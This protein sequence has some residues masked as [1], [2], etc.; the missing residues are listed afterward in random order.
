MTARFHKVF[1]VVAS[2]LV[3]IA[4]VWGFVLA[5]S[6]FK[7]RLQRLD[8]QRLTDLQDI[9]RE[10]QA[11]VRDED[12]KETL[13]QPLPQTLEEAAGRARYRK[14]NLYDPETGE[15]YRYTRKDETTYEL[16][17][18]FALPRD[19]DREVFWNHAA[20]EQCF[21]IDALDPP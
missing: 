13:K 3:A 1:F 14:L 4:I 6:P 16:C 2:T 20:G 5:G 15:P 7:T 12:E 19:A 8:D 10:I 18:T 11:L 21:T 9:Y 17:A